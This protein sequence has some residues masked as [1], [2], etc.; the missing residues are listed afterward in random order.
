MLLD[1]ASTQ[2]LTPLM[3]QY[4]EIK[5]QYADALVLFQVGDFY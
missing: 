3:Q 1:T 5:N 4:F 2:A